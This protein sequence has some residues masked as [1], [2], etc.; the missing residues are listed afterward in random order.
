MG[1]SRSQKKPY[2][3]ATLAFLI[4]SDLYSIK[5]QF[6]TFIANCRINYKIKLFNK[7]GRVFLFSSFQGSFVAFGRD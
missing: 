1:L 3:Y 2:K 7:E 6:L 5:N 4:G